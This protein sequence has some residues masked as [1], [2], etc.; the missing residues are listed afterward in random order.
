MDKVRDDFIYYGNRVKDPE[1]D[2]CLLA[3]Y[4]AEGLMEAE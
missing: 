3:D 4:T 1:L 2:S